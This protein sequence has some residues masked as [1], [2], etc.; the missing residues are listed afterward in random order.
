MRSNTSAGE[1]EPTGEKYICAARVY[2][3]E[4]LSGTVMV[5]RLGPSLWAGE[6]R[7]N[8]LDSSSQTLFIVFFILVLRAQ[9]SMDP[10]F[11][12]IR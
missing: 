11:S 8:I 5:R 4:T 2:K 1:Q 9:S 3:V 12:R 7:T 6:L 10:H